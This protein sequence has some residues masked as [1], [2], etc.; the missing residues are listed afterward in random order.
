MPYPHSNQE[1][2][3]M[4]NKGE[5]NRYYQKHREYVQAKNQ[6]T[7]FARR[8]KRIERYTARKQIRKMQAKGAV[9]VGEYR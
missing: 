2:L 3:E 5:L 4:K 8:I 1:W 6:D 9:D 7:A